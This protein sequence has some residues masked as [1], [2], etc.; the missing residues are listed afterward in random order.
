MSHDQLEDVLNAFR[1]MVEKIFSAKFLMALMFSATA[2]FAMMKGTLSVEAFMALA[3]TAVS[4]YFN[5][6]EKG[7]TKNEPSKP[8]P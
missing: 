6:E 3:G 2:C 8:I 4:G 1:F 7:L 5:K